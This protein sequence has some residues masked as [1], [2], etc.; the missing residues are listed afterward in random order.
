MQLRLT[1]ETSV[2]DALFRVKQA[3]LQKQV[4]ELRTSEF[5]TL[6]SE[7]CFNAIRHGSES[8]LEFDIDG[9]IARLEIRDTGKGFSHLGETAF[10]EGFTTSNSLGVGL[11]GIVRMADDF[12]LETSASGTKIKIEKSVQDV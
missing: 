1:D 2:R 5:V 8:A 10:K 7:L 3:L 6:T 12:D 9:G 4:S 11:G